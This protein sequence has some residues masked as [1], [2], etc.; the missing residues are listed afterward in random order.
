MLEYIYRGKRLEGEDILVGQGEDAD[1]RLPNTGLYKDQAIAVV[2]ISGGTHFLIRLS[3][4]FDIRVNGQQM[5]AF[6]P[7]NASDV[8]MVEGETIRCKNASGGANQNGKRFHP[9]VVLL[10]PVLVISLVLLALKSS[11]NISEAQAD[12]YTSS[13]YQVSVRQVILQALRGGRYYPVDSVAVETLVGTGF[14]TAEGRFITAR[15]VAEPWMNPADSALSEWSVLVENTNRK[16]GRDTLRLISSL[17]AVNPEGFKWLFST[18]TAHINRS[19]DRVY[20]AGTRQAPRWKRSIV[21]VYRNFD[22]ELG[23]VAWFQFPSKGLFKPVD[24]RSF[25]NLKRGFGQNRGAHQRYWHYFQKRPGEGAVL[26]LV[27]SDK[28]SLS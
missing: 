24:S 11:R 6:T 18:D 9:V 1:I 2:R 13:M 21:G 15:H 4:Q 22:C 12:K 8:I 28:R 14:V 16:V 17:Q 10:L 7:L 20:N 3:P 23:D 25:S 27:C 5:G 26:R 19:R